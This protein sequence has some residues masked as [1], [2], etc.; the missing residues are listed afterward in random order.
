MSRPSVVSAYH[1]GETEL[2]HSPSL[3]SSGLLAEAHLPNH[4]IV[5]RIPQGVCVYR[6]GVLLRFANLSG[7]ELYRPKVDHQAGIIIS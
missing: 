2:R 3:E 1:D 5:P 7:S 6:P 4:I